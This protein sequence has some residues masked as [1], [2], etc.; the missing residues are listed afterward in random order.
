MLGAAGVTCF[1]SR[2][3]NHV[4]HLLYRFVQ[5]SDATAARTIG[6]LYGTLRGR[7]VHLLL[8]NLTSRETARLLRCV[9]TPL[10][11]I[12]GPLR[13]AVMACAIQVGVLVGQRQS[14]PRA[15]A[16]EG[17]V[18]LDRAHGVPL[19]E[20]EEEQALG[21]CHCFPSLDAGLEY[22]EQAYLQVSL[23]AS[24]IWLN[25]RPGRLQHVSDA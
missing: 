6:T 10:R 15:A 20:G 22:C 8:A 23:L 21:G 18:M 17:G 16:V 2:A 14:R 25:V 24:N 5:G 12:D 1:C 11:C 13:A 9:S 7:G 3:S 4:C 19:A